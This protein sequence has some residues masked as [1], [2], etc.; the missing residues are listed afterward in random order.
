ML[1]TR[2]ASK[3]FLELTLWIK[4]K[5]GL[6]LPLHPSLPIFS[7]VFSIHI[8]L[9]FRSHLDVVSFYK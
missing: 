5:K 6:R 8:M 4:K 7:I 1:C 9:N 3:S 2:K